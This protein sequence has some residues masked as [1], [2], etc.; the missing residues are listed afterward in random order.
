MLL[1]FS[2]YVATGNDFVVLD[3]RNQLYDASDKKIW[4][5]VCKTK[6]GVGA[7]GVLMV[8]NSEKANI[9][10][11]M[12]YLNSDGGEVS[13]CG[14]GARAITAFFHHECLGNKESYL[15]E[16]KNGIYQC[17]IDPQYGYRLKMTELYDVAKFDIS[18]LVNSSHSLY[19]N[20]GVPHCVFEVRDLATFNVHDIGRDV[21]NNKLFA[22]GSNANFYERIGE[23]VFKVRTYER[24]VEAET[25]AC[26]TGATAVAICVA[27]KYNIKNE[28][29][30]EVP[31]GILI[32]R[33]NDD[34]STIELCGAAQ[35]VFNGKME[36]E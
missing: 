7:D 26:G 14:N 28:V 8:E 21:R 22:E 2:K 1:T 5:Q 23:N 24:G 33:F 10:F 34:F 4:E 32:I 6:W 20:T 30:L 16:T 18:K 27:K 36:V 12:R 17:A 29:I 15:F 31:G 25:L 9:D 3:N 35:K 11:K 13:M 19:L